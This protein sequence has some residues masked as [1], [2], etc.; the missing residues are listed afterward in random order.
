MGA[1]KL[2][3]SQPNLFLAFC[4]GVGLLGAAATLNS[5]P[6]FDPSH[7]PPGAPAE[8]ARLA[9]ADG[10]VAG[11]LKHTQGGVDDNDPE[12]VARAVEELT[13]VWGRLPQRMIDYPQDFL[14]PP[15]PSVN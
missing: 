7:M 8:H 2:P 10:M 9:L 13:V 4:K 5:L 3:L 6:E 15:D 11:Y 14:P 12:A 1:K